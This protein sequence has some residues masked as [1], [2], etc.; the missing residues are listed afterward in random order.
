MSLVYWLSPD[1]ED[2][3]FDYEDEHVELESDKDEYN[4][5]DEDEDEDE[6]D[7]DD[8]DDDDDEDDDFAPA[9][10]VLEPEPAALEP[11]AGEGAGPAAGGAAGAAG[12]AGAAL[13]AGAAGGA[14][15]VT[16]AGGL[17]S[18]IARGTASRTDCPTLV[19]VSD[20]G[21]SWATA[22]AGSESAP[23]TPTSNDPARTLP[24]LIWLIPLLALLGTANY[25]R[26]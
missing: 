21:P 25:P 2:E 19:T 18:R 5:E 12:T 26:P 1:D 17:A 13:G 10:R 7:E 9:A 24:F 14:D 8:D 15:R 4:S 3:D 22:A 6:D 16:G 23:A 20:T 11:D